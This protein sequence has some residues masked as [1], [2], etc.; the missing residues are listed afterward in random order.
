MAAAHRMSSVVQH[1]EYSSDDPPSWF[2]YDSEG[3]P[4]EETQSRIQT[5]N[6]SELI[7]K[8]SFSSDEESP[9]ANLI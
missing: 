9:D 5:R 3:N 7:V 8:E 1:Q 4:L 2:G 6:Y